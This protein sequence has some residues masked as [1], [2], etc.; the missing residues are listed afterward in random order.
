MSS[1]RGHKA[2]IGRRAPLRM[3]LVRGPCGPRPLCCSRLMARR[4]TRCVRFAHSTQ[5]IAASRFTKRASRAAMRRCAARRRIGA[6]PA[7]RPRLCGA[8]PVLGV[9]ERHTA[10]I[11]PTPCAEPRACGAPAKRGFNARDS[12]LTP[13]QERA[14]PRKAVVGRRAQR[15][16][17]G[18]LRPSTAG[19]EAR[20]ASHEPHSKRSTPPGRGFAQEQ[21]PA[22]TPDGAISNVRP[23]GRYVRF[24]SG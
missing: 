23:I 17:G 16:C 5:T 21:T 14:V 3:R 8:P 11:E 22:K 9:E 19:D 15:L 12:P 20:S 2:A 10:G 18:A 13:P 7:A 6:A 4:K 1:S 24:L